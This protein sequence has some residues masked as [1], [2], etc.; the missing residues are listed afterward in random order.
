MR[1]QLEPPDVH[2]ECVDKDGPV[3]EHA[4]PPFWNVIIMVQRDASLKLQTSCKSC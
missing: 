2:H 3:E 4:L 1:E